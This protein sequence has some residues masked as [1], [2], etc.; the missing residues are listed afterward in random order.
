MIC[1]DD[2]R[3]RHR[4]SVANVIWAGAHCLRAPAP[5]V[6]VLRAAMRA[7]VRARLLVDISRLPP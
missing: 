7:A 1:A 5:G 3:L 2:V 4:A 6:R